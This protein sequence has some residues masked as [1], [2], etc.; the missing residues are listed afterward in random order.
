MIINLHKTRNRLVA[1]FVFIFLPII[2]K[3][4]IE[5]GSENRQPQDVC[6]SLLAWNEVK[7]R[8]PLYAEATV[9]DYDSHKWFRVQRRAGQYHADVQPLTAADTATMK[10]ICGGWSWRRRAVAVKLE[11]G[12]QIAG[13]M[14]CMPHGAGAIQGNNFNGHFCIHFMDSTTHGS[15]KLDLAHQIMVWKAADQI[16]P[17]LMAMGPQKTLEV[18]FTA[19]NQGD[20]SIPRRI[21]HRPDTALLSKIFTIHSVQVLNL[22]KVDEKKY[23]LDIRISYK[24]SP[25]ILRKKATINM[26]NSEGIWQIEK[27]SLLPLFEDI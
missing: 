1:G 18:L 15:R 20:H 12:Q 23:F 16:G 3:I 27:D 22:Q 4:G 6:G 21:I 10:E 26:I 5:Q 9:I 8:F 2:F 24:D 25:Q 19:I 11:D 17:R 7:E 14:A 13:S